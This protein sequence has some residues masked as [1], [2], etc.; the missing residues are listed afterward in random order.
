MPEIRRSATETLM[1][2]ME[3]FDKHEPKECLIIF[4]DE[5]GDLVWNS[6]SDSIVVKLG[7]LN[8]ALSKR[9]SST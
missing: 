2:A 9:A 6:T 5:A 1:T 4:T 8:S 3:E 7:W